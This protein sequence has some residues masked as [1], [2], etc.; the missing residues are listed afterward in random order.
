MP[1]LTGPKTAIFLDTTDT[2]VLLKTAD[3]QNPLARATFR[4][5]ENPEKRPEKCPF[6]RF[7]MVSQK[8]AKFRHFRQ[9][10]Q[11]VPNPALNTGLLV[12]FSDKTA[13]KW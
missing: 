1:V 13:E 12:K 2:T 4:A 11:K 7:V 10:C 8:S 9:I 6:S 3:C 5:E